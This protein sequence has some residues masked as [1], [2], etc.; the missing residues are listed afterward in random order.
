MLNVIRNAISSRHSMV[1][2]RTNGPIYSRNK[3]LWERERTHMFKEN[4]DNYQQFQL[5]DLIWILI[6]NKSKRMR[7]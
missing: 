7:K 5:M 1:N 6:Q 2:F 4:Q 3:L